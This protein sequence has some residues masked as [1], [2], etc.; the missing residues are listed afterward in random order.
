PA[1][2]GLT[3][4]AIGMPQSTIEQALLTHVYSRVFDAE[5]DI[6]F[7]Q[8][9]YE[10]R[11]LPKQGWHV[12]IPFAAKEAGEYALPP[13]QIQYFNPATG[14]LSIAASP[15]VSLIIKSKWAEDMTKWLRL[16]G[17]IVL[18]LAVAW[19]LFRY[20]QRLLHRSR[21]RAKLDQCSDW[22]AVKAVVDDY[23]LGEG[24]PELERLWYCQVK[25]ELDAIK[26]AVRDISLAR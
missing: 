8:A 9:E 26:L 5:L 20:V 3:V 21:Y 4:D 6:Q 23:N 13:L 2:W 10:R 11:A 1:F 18:L 7:Y 19:F 17:L 22:Q 24:N 25:P 14:R 16:G 15:S 12:R